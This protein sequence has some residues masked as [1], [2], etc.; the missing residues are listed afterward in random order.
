MKR[1]AVFLDR[2]GVINNA[3][4]KNGRPYPP[5]SLRELRIDK[6]APSALSKLKRLGF[7]L[8]VVTNQPDIARGTITAETVRQINKKLM[9]ELPIDDIRVC[10]HDDA[11]KCG[12]RK[13]E[14]GLIIAA[15]KEYLIDLKKSFMIGDRHKDIEA[16]HRAGL[17][18]V[19]IDHG[20]I[21][22]E[23][24]S[25]DCT[26]YSLKDGIEWILAVST[27]EKKELR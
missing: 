5:R 27:E 8:I 20:Y 11:G 2:D 15:A 4:V 25:P 21:E 18:T 12:C 23:N 24:L 16:G 6:D 14:P 7:L 19:F 10:P 9:L 22:T 1:R 26:V 3:V 17:K 13:P